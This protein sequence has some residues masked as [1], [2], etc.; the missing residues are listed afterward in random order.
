[1]DRHLPRLSNAEGG[2]MMRSH[3]KPSAGV[4]IGVTAL[5]AALGGTGYAAWSIPTNS[6]GT[7]QLK[8]GAV[9]KAKLNVRGVRVPFAQH[10][11]TA[12]TAASAQSAIHANMADNATNSNHAS[13]ADTAITASQATNASHAASA[14]IAITASNATNAS[15]AVTA[16]RAI[17]ADNA[18]QLGGMPAGS[19]MIYSATLPPL[20]TETGAWGG[21]FTAT[22]AGQS[23]SAVTSFAVPLPTSLDSVHVE[24]V[25]G[26]STASCSGVGHADPGYLCLYTLSALNGA[27]PSFDDLS[28]SSGAS[29]N[30]FV[31]VVTSTLSGFTA[32]TGTYA[33]T[34]P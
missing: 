12:R 23:A 15:H 31:V 30:G 1:M 11:R 5:F 4:A 7:K 20:A 29:R 2:T 6:V 8:N 10:A 32:L 17:T 9:T 18:T 28:G 26:P 19:Y 25:H 33:V 27:S 3:V 16:D 24:Y 34:A 14:D 22:A 13:T 21:G